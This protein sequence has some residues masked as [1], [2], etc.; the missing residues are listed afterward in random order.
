MVG[1]REGQ[2][3]GTDGD[4]MDEEHVEVWATVVAVEGDQARVRLEE[5]G[6]GR[7]G[8]PGGCGG[9]LGGRLD[10]ATGPIYRVS[11]PAGSVA[12]ERVRV[13]LPGSSVRRSAMAAYAYPLLALLAG[14]VGGAELGGEAG[15]LAGA[16]AGLGIGWL[17]LRRAEGRCRRD[18]SLRPAIRP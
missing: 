13:I 12:G 9:R 11:N 4:P 8:G 6:C 14:A 5:S 10:C 16:L 7:C 18:E 2:A 15:A 17:Q 1:A 3:D